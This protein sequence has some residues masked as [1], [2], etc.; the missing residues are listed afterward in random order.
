[1][2]KLC[3]IVVACLVGTTLLSCGGGGD[4]STGPPVLTTL[5]VSFPT[6][7]IQVSQSASATVTGLDQ[8]GASI[9]TGTV[10]WSTGSTAVASVNASGVVTGVTAGQT[11]VIASA[12]G[13]SG[14]APVAVIPIPVASVTVSPPTAT[15]AVGATQQLVATTLD[16]GGNTLTGRVVTWATSDQTKATISSTGLVTAVDGGQATMMATS[17][18]RSGT[19]Q[20]TVTGTG[21][22]SANAVQLSIGGSRRLTAA[23]TAS[24]CIGSSL[25]PSEYV[26]IP[27]NSTNVAASAIQLQI[28][29]TNTTAI[30]P[31]QVASLQPGAN[32]SPLLNV[33]PSKSFERAFRERERRDLGSVFAA[34]RQ[35]PRDRRLPRSRQLPGGVSGDLTPTTPSF[36]TGIPADP[37]VGATY[38]INGNISGNTCTA[39]KQLRG[40]RVITVLTRTIVLSDE[41][42]PTG[43][44]TDAEMTAFGQEFENNGYPVTV[45][46][47]GDPT[48]I[49]VNNG[50]IAI[51]FT[52]GVNV[53]PAPPGAFVGGLF[54]ARDL[55]PE[56][57]PNSC[58]A[59]NEGEMFYMPVPDPGNT[60]NTDYSDKTILSRGVLGILAHELQHLINAGRRI[61]VNN[62]SSFEEVW[63]NE[64]LSHIAEELLYYRISGNTPQSNIDSIRVRS[65]TA[66][67]EAVNT[68]Q[69][70]NLG[71]VLTYMESPETNSPFSLVD[72][73]ETRGAIWQLLRYTADRRGGTEQL[74]WSALVNSTVAGQANFNNVL[75]D[76]ITMSR[77][78]VVAQFADDAGLAV[79]ANFTHPSWNFRGILPAINSGIFPLLTRPLSTTQLNITLNGGGAAYLRFGVAIDVPA[80]IVAT[81]S[82]QPVPPAVEF[83][84]M[85]TQ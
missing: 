13:K 38:Q 8:F 81:S 24:L 70:N 52:P 51:L 66:Q 41:T 21:C 27:F 82:G 47:F 32:L 72:G 84:I 67:R 74:A 5:S 29:G 58:P 14:Q 76:I 64:G 4:G 80:K 22:T 9:A 73:L 23:E 6:G 40:A 85:R 28:T 33:S 20:I 16:A 39:P 34:T 48:D 35:L 12:G 19:S 15:L 18:G 83:I 53:I 65:T 31:G 30:Q 37:V 1:M 44:Y 68:Y 2:Q 3:R 77:D 42:S 60:I 57:G 10:S 26:L 54:A 69:I 50:R 43:G 11:Q 17:E 71:R 56:S 78:W 61:Y 79:S 7:T 36:L 63:L 49:D 46:N 45:Q 55:F 75:G 59:S 25:S 62:A